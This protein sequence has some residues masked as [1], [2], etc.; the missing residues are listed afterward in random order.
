M[1]GVKGT[2]CAEAIVNEIRPG[3]PGIALV[4]NWRAAQKRKDDAESELN[5]ARCALSNSE[6]AFVKWL[7]PDGAK[8]GEV[9]CLPIYDHFIEVHIKGEN[10]YAER[11]GEPTQRAVP[12][13]Q[14]RDGKEPKPKGTI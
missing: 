7:V 12:V 6:A 1:L 8:I 3:E 13:V 4:R 9:F 10:M 5:S 2:R 14:W 11:G